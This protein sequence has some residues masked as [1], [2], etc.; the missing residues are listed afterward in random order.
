M[1]I[2]AIFYDEY[3]R[4]TSRTEETIEDIRRLPKYLERPGT[5]Q[6]TTE[7]KGTQRRPTAHAFNRHLNEEF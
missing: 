5:V 7:W 1:A 2:T 3:G 4:I 6:I